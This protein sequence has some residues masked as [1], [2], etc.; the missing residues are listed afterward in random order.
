MN[1]VLIVDSNV[2]FQKALTKM[3][4]QKDGFKVM[5]C[6]ARGEQA[7]DFCKENHPDIIFMDIMLSGQGGLET[8][9]Q[10]KEIIPEII[11]CIVSAYQQLSFMQEAL[12]LDVKGYLNKPIST[13]AVWNFLKGYQSGDSI[14][15]AEIIRQV[16]DIIEAKDFS[17]VY[18]QSR[19]LAQQILTLTSGD[20]AQSAKVLCS[21]ESFLLAQYFANP[22]EHATM[23]E[24]FPINEELLDDCIV[25]EMWLNKVFDYVYKHRFIE[26]YAS[27]RPVFEYIDEHVKEYIS[28]VAITENCH[29]SQQ[30]ILRL[31]KEQM[32]M[33]TLDYIQS[34][35]MTLAKWYL[36]LGEYSTL[37]VAMM[38]GYGD[39]GYLSKVFKKYENTTPHQY[40]VS[41]QQAKI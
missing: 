21:I 20:K 10:I 27:A 2:L 9:R 16:R 40:K 12:K 35:K 6:F 22:F 29:I 32:K 34:R 24:K 5:A 19:P 14:D 39:A 28:M 25:V 4:E 38:L 23:K 26:R 30:Y 41:L 33:G 11:I 36:Y 17:L 1:N 31:F 13:S 3:I 15:D 18:K 7:L 37:D 8:A